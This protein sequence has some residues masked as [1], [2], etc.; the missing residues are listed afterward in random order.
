MA[1]AD[2]SGN[3]APPPRCIGLSADTTVIDCAVTSPK[4]KDITLIRARPYGRSH[5]LDS[6]YA[7]FGGCVGG[8]DGTCCGRCGRELPRCHR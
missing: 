7:G 6:M 2:A 8:A 4:K 3:V 5:L 1:L